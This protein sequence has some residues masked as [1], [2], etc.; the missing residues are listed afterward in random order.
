MAVTKKTA[1]KETAPKNSVSSFDVADAYRNHS[2]FLANC[3]EVPIED[4]KVTVSAELAATLNQ[5][6][7]LK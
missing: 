4:G 3:V 2:S 5:K 7:Y 1:T 6:G